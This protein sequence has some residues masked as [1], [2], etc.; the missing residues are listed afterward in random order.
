MY[1]CFAL[2]LEH[3]SIKYLIFFG[4]YS[5]LG[6]ESTTCRVYSRTFVPL[7]HDV[8]LEYNVKQII[9]IQLNRNQLLYQA[10][11]KLTPLLR[12]KT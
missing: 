3:E 2:L 5:D 10:S 8:R 7:C 4:T 9:I 12:L 6:I 11:T 1:V